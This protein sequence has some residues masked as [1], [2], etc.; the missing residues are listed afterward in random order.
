MEKFN[1]LEFKR[2]EQLYKARIGKVYDQ[3]VAHS[4]AT[5]RVEQIGSVRGVTIDTNLHNGDRIGNLYCCVGGN[6]DGYFKGI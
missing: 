4:L 1:E 3:K 5:K 2:I 6:I